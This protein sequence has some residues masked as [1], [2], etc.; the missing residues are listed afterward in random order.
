[1]QTTAQTTAAPMPCD[2]SRTAD[3]VEGD[4]S[5]VLRRIHHPKVA[6][7]LWHRDLPPR[8]C[9]WLTSL[10]LG[11]LPRGRL[12]A[13]KAEFDCAF[14]EFLANSETPRSEEAALFVADAVSITTLFAEIAETALVDISLTV[15]QHDSCWKFHRDQVTLRALTTYFGPGTQYVDAPDA[16]RALK[17]QKAFGGPVREIPTHTIAMFKGETDASNRGV[18]HRSPPIAATGRSRLVLTLNRP[19]P[20]SPDYRALRRVSRH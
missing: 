15:I 11:R 10:P 3:T 6:L 17:E 8:L 12:L 19:S 4:R 1:M 9:H 5:K 14:D 13:Q 18:V 7:A 16:R 2:G 20:T